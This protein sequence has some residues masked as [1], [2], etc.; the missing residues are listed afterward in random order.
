MVDGFLDECGVAGGVELVGWG[1]GGGEG[2]IFF[3]DSF[4]LASDGGA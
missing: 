3:E 4:D 2:V 1:V